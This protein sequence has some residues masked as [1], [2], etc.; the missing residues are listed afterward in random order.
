RRR[1]RPSPGRPAAR[2]RAG[3]ARDRRRRTRP[4]AAEPARE[5]EPH[6][7]AAVHLSVGH[8]RGR[9]RDLPA[10]VLLRHQPHPVLGHADPDLHRPAELRRRVPGPAGAHLGGQH[11][12]L[13]A[14]RGAAGS[15]G[16]AAARAGD[17][18]QRAR[19][20]GVPH[21]AV[22]ALSDPDV[23]DVLHLHRVRQPAVRHRQPVPGPVRDAG[24][25][26]A[27]RAPL[28]EDRDH[29]D[30]AAGRRQRGAD[31]PRRAAEHPSTLYEAA[32]ID[33]AGRM[34]QFTAITLPLLTPTILFNLIT[35]VSG[36][37][38][39]FTEAYIMTDG[40]PDNA[41]LFY[42]LYLYRNA[43]SYG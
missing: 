30:G 18:P 17:E 8:R 10:G 36:A 7:G 6:H 24:H 35:G 14:D 25:E 29:P 2:C 33:G 27:G 9:L 20:G 34:K 22:P 1:A 16:G 37:M 15:G 13:H 38:M 4:S 21:P 42:M 40:G 11:G 5:A 32:R 39:V 19:G 31:L 3:P 28:R 26:P 43:F 23:R 41:T 12:L